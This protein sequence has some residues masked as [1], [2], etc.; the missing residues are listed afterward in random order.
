MSRVTISGNVAGNRESGIVSE[1]KLAGG[2][3]DIE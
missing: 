2:G 3:G 1:S